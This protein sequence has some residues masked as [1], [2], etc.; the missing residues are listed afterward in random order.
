MASDTSCKPVFKTACFLF[1]WL[2]NAIIL[3]LKTET[4]TKMDIKK[5]VKT[6]F[7]FVAMV[8]VV[9]V[10][11]SFQPTK[12]MLANVMG[13][14]THSSYSVN[15]DDK[16]I[17]VEIVEKYISAG[18][19]AE[20]VVLSFDNNPTSAYCRPGTEKKEVMQIVLESKKSEG[21][22]KNIILKLSG[23]EPEM[24][25]NLYLSDSENILAVAETHQEYFRFNNLDLLIAQGESLRLHLLAD[26]S[27]ELKPGQR[28]RFD[29]EDEDDVFLVVNQKLC[30]VSEIFP[31]LGKYLTIV[32]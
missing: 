24:I 20:N 8:S 18:F 15:Y 11:S 14:A 17:G 2:K 23:V 7:V 16:N 19:D 28:L 32:R 22:F 4:K 29:L 10:L 26:F 9:A 5:I 3:R 1:F 25:K 6:Y 27:D 31:V 30:S 12:S 13:A 21:Y